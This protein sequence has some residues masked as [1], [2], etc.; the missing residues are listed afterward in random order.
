MNPVNALLGP[1]EWLGSSVQNGLE[2]LRLGGFETEEESA[3]YEVRAERRNFRLRRYFPDAAADATRPAL[4]LVPPMMLDAGVFDVAPNSSGV[5]VLNELGIDAWVVDFGAPDR[6]EGGLERNLTDHVIAVSEAIDIAREILGHDVSI[7]GYSQGGMFCYQVAAYRRSKGLVSVVTFG[8]PVDTR[9]VLE[10]FGIPEDIGLRPR[11]WPT[12][13]SAAKP[14]PDGS[15]AP[16][17]ACWTQSSRSAPGW[18]S[19]WRC[20]TGRRCCPGSVSAASWAAKAS[21]RGRAPRSPSCSTSS[22]CTTG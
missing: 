13:C 16:G 3:P 8:S 4:L 6:E 22:W 5:T 10:R 11:S 21:S 15:P 20:T 9:I 17:F 14:Y 2:V 19:C 1:L 7:G 18:T 12:T